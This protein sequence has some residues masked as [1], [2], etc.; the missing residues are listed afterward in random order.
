MRTPATFLL[1]LVVAA[2]PFATAGEKKEGISIRID[3]EDSRAKIAPR[4]LAR[5]ARLA[6]PTRRGAV[7]LLLTD[8][9]V[10]VQLSDHTMAKVEAEPDAGFLEEL[11]VSG[12]RLAVGKSIEVPITDLR[13]AEVRGGVLVLTTNEGKPAFDGVEVDG[14]NV[15]HG[16]SRADADRFV[17]AFRKVKAGR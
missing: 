11:I 17:R 12:V 7:T 6:I 14:E 13:S 3:S 8:E 15:T 10:A 4:R 9:V 2:A 5:E 1:A 16:V